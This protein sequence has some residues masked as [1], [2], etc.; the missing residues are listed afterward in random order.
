M[1]CLSTRIGKDWEAAHHDHLN[2]SVC[3]RGWGKIGRPLT[4]ATRST[5]SASTRTRKNRVHRYVD[6][7]EEY[8][9][10]ATFMMPSDPHCILWVLRAV[11]H[12]E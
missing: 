2:R 5:M 9:P 1:G 7:S 10:K 4:I 12:G 8:P 6:V 11:A 3:L